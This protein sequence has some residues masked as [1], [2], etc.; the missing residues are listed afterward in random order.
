MGYQGAQSHRVN[1]YFDETK[2]IPR[3]RNNI[4]V[5]R[6]YVTELRRLREVLVRMELTANRPTGTIHRGDGLGPFDLLCGK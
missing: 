2:I 3:T 6:N 4:E 5:R 1:N